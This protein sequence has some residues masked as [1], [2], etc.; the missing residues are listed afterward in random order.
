MPSASAKLTTSEP[1]PLR[2]WRRSMRSC[3]M[4]GPPRQG[5]GSALDRAHD[6]QVGA[7]AAQIVGERLLDVAVRGV[8]VPVEQLLGH[9]DHAI[10][11]VAALHRLLVDEGLLDRMR[12]LDR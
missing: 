1:A 7:A 6:A 2:S 4:S 12:L 5:R 3:G 11:A 10:D 9:H 8:A